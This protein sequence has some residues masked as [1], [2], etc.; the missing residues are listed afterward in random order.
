MRYT[1]R[2]E[3]P[4]DYPEINELVK[5]SFATNADDDGTTHEY[6]NA[7][8]GKDVFIPQLSLVAEAAD[9]MLI[10]QI[11]LYKTT[12][13]TSRGAVSELLLSPICV[14]PEYF[15][16]G[17]ARALVAESLPIAFK[18]GYRAVFLCGDPR[19][20]SRLGFVP[21]YQYNIRHIKEDTAEWSMVRELY[22]GALNGVTGTINTI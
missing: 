21:S 10:G 9:G 12:V 2:Q 22:S 1:I 7:L 20:Y 4:S 11:V 3:R 6:L 19:F 17:I 14:H 8:R 16:C 5:K 18:L 15:R 13:T